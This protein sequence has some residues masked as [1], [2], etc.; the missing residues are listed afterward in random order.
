M[1][2]QL[3]VL[4]AAFRTPIVPNPAP[5]LVPRPLTPSHR[6][7]C[8]SGP[9]GTPTTAPAGDG[10]AHRQVQRP[11]HKPHNEPHIAPP[12]PHIPEIKEVNPEPE[13]PEPPSHI[14]NGEAIFWCSLV[15]IVALGCIIGTCVLVRK[16]A[17]G[18]GYTQVN[19]DMDLNPIYNESGEADE[20]QPSP[21]GGRFR[22]G[23]KV[24]GLR[25]KANTA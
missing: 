17:M 7:P 6:L 5:L 3:G 14:S 12:T 22:T 9:D 13:R 25:A 10:D 16:H 1:A 4:P 2:R 19:E 8:S 20:S 15:L 18:G 23:R 24:K 21:A 11:P